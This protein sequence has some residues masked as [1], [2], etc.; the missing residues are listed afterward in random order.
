MF[1]YGTDVYKQILYWE[2]RTFNVTRRHHRIFF[3]SSARV[4]QG[5]RRGTKKHDHD[6][7]RRHILQCIL[8]LFL[9][10]GRSRLYI[11]YNIYKM[12]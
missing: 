3:L 11:V 8:L 9:L 12:I 7:P 6:G 2:R 4:S 10:F 5:R 1:N